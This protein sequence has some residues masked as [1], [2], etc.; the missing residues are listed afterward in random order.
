MTNS[1]NKP[2]HHYLP[3][4]CGRAFADPRRHRFRFL[5]FDPI[6]L[7]FRCNVNLRLSAVSYRFVKV[8]S[9]SR[10]VEHRRATCGELAAGLTLISTWNSH[11]D[12]YLEFPSPQIRIDFNNAAQPTRPTSSW[13]L[14]VTILSSPTDSPTSTYYGT[15]YPNDTKSVRASTS[16]SYDF[17]I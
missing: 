11:T 2:I 10:S 8:Y 17:L 14:R 13:H 5:S 12:H 9:N 7:L 15:F 1:S 6:L 4:S 3:R 16:S